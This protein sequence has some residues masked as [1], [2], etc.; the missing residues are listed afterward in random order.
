MES[1]KPNNP[2]TRAVKAAEA[3]SMLGISRRF[4]A[5]LTK[6]GKIACH[7]Y[8]PRTVTYDFEELGRFR[9]ATFTGPSL[10]ADPDQPGNDN[11]GEK[12]ETRA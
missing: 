4:L 2:L 8:G 9:A 12:N 11:Q 10:S 6:E 7:R 5:Q 3:A 1:N